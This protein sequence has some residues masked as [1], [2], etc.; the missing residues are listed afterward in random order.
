MQ[1]FAFGGILL[2]WSIIKTNLLYVSFMSISIAIL[3]AYFVYKYIYGTAPNK[4][5]NAIFPIVEEKTDDSDFDIVLSSDDSNDDSDFDVI[6]SSFDDDDDDDEVIDNNNNNN[7]NNNNKNDNLDQNNS[8][9]DSYDSDSSYDDDSYCSVLD[10]HDDNSDDDNNDDDG[11]DID[12]DDDGDYDDDNSNDNCDE[13]DITFLAD[14][15]DDI[16][17]D[18]NNAVNN[19]NDD[20]NDNNNN[21]I[22]DNSDNHIRGEETTLFEI[23]FSIDSESSC[24]NNS[25]M[26]L[27]YDDASDVETNIACLNDSNEKSNSCD[28]DSLLFNSE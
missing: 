28:S 5:L 17:N 13:F 19:N 20:D 4:N 26:T 3:I 1:P 18:D 11:D 6:V 7:N 22:D 24:F 16:N 8:D 2:I 15:N 9:D 21:D 12:I 25:V 10:D 23:D 14:I 27:I